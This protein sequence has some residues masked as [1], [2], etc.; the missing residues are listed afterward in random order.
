MRIFYCLL[1]SLLL[2]LP[3]G[4]QIVGIR[5]TGKKAE[6]KYRKYLTEIDG[7]RVICGEFKF[8]IRYKAKGSVEI[9]GP[10][11]IELWVGDTVNPEKVPYKLVGEDKVA[12]G[13]KGFVKISRDH[14]P[15]AN[16]MKTVARDQT[17]Y[18]L[19]S[20]YK[21]RK[22]AIDVSSAKVKEM[23][24]GTT[25]W[26]NA[27][28]KVMARCDRLGA[29]LSAGV[30]KAAGRKWKAKAEKIRSSLKGDA[31]A[32]RK[33][34]ALK[35]AQAA[36][37]PDGL[38]EITDKGKRLTMKTVESMHTRLI[39]DTTIIS[40]KRALDLSKKAEEIIEGFRRELVDPYAEEFEDNIPDKIFVEFF[41]M[42]DDV[43]LFEAYWREF[44]GRVF[45][46][47]RERYLKSTGQR[48]HNLRGNAYVHFSRFTAEG[49]FEGSIAHQLGH[50]LA[51][52]HFNNDDHRG[53][54]DWLEEGCAY[55]V[56]FEFLGRNTVTCYQLK[57]DKYDTKVGAEGLKTLQTGQRESFNTLALK[58]AV[59]LH[60]LMPK[61]LF[62][63]QDADLAKCWSFFDF[64]ARKRTDKIVEFLRI[65]CQAARSKGKFH[66]EVRELGGPV[67]GVKAGEDVFKYLDN[68][69]KAYAKSGQKK[70]SKRKKRR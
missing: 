5:L 31:L 47:D 53:T 25:A 59:P 51:N 8:G 26:F 18:G 69:W 52:V 17:F 43:E 68:A 46:K 2:S 16:Y 30:F 10:K 9:F 19:A 54:M 6:K 3:A 23:K 4:A 57:H 20:E 62:Q 15:K 50:D 14:I 34:K 66:S 45:T 67:F 64:L 58:A 7:E 37:N 40:P 28:R 48:A 44:Y 21:L 22:E 12:V 1:L 42:H 33:G 35:S 13:K 56:S 60:S 32:E 49:D 11:H 70:S 24:K 61:E 55:Y 63:M 39:Y 65:T 38:D 29:W 41:F 27:Q 36:N